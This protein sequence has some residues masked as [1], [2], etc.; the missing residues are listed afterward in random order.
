MYE[1]SE[2]IAKSCC[3][4][5]IR[6]IDAFF[7]RE[8]CYVYALWCNDLGSYR[9]CFCLKTDEV[10]SDYSFAPQ[11]LRFEIQNST[12]FKKQTNKQ[13]ITKTRPCR[14]SICISSSLKPMGVNVN[15]FWSGLLCHQQCCL[16]VGVVIQYVSSVYCLW[17]G[18]MPE[19]PIILIV[20]NQAV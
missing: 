10:K 4:V 15:M 11:P 1:V 12:G 19:K 13:N 7:V 2:R 16:A 8:I 18:Q 6:E 17:L 9:F 20:L 14:Y 3:M 5:F